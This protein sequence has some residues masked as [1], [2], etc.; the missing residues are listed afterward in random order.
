MNLPTRMA[1]QL[2]RHE[3]RIPIRLPSA[4]ALRPTVRTLR[5]RHRRCELRDI[6]PFLSS[7]YSGPMGGASSLLERSSTIESGRL[8]EPD[9]PVAKTLP[10]RQPDSLLAHPGNP[11]HAVCV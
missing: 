11:Q 10:I 5:H 9:D 4:I 6:P 1:Y 8:G 3:Q 2:I 7:C